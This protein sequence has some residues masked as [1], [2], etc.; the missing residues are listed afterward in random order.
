MSEECHEL[1]SIKYKSALYNNEKK[2]TEEN[3]SNL[4]DFLINEKESLTKETWTKINK[5]DKIEKFRIYVE[6]YSKLH[7]LNEENS[8]ELLNFLSE[9]LDRKRLLKTK[10]VVYNKETGKITSIPSL[11]FNNSSK[12]YT[13]KRCEKRVS[14]LKSLAPKKKK[15]DKI[16][17]PDKTDKIDINK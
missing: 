15:S 13:L 7:K 14:T 9:N 3:M 4:E 2:E 12:K 10:E 16:N 11:S 1:K 5:T 17:K 8:K 6:E